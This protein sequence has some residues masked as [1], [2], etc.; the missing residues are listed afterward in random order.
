VNRG[1]AII[2]GVEAG[3]EDWKAG[4]VVPHGQAMD[5]LDRH[6][7]ERLAARKAGP[8]KGGRRSS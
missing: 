6:I 3:I 1:A 2:E 4:R 8:G 7:D 5:E